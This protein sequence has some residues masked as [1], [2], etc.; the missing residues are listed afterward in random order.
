MESKI[1]KTAF[2]YYIKNLNYCFTNK[3]KHKFNSY[4]S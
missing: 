4:W 2:G 1:S 3:L